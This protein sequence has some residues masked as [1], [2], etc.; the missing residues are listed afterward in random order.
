MNKTLGY[1]Y[2]ALGVILILSVFMRITKYIGDFIRLFKIFSPEL[3]GFQRGEI[4]GSAIGRLLILG[5][6][7]FLFKWGNK[8]VT[9]KT[10]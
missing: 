5:L 9:S 8:N 7:Y 6:I 3:N 4:I 10:E 2:Y 1:I